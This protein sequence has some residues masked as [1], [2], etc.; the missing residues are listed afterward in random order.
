[1]N[2][3]GPDDMG[4]PVVDP[5]PDHINPPRSTE[6]DPYDND[7]KYD[8][9]GDSDSV[10]SA[11]S[12]TSHTTGRTPHTDLTRNHRCFFLSPVTWHSGV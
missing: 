5:M 4:Y 6:I 12:F 11:G 9:V 7:A 10:G 3:D 8:L 1:M 2:L